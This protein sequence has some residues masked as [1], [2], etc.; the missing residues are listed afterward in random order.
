MD[1]SLSAPAD[2]TSSLFVPV[3]EDRYGDIKN[4]GL[5]QVA[6][7][8]SKQ[9]TSDLFAAEIILLQKGGPEKHLHYF[10]D[11]WFYALEGVLLF[12]V[13]DE[14]YR[15][16]P[17]DSVFAKKMVPHTWANISDTRMRLIALHTPAG[18]IEDFFINAARF[19]MPPGPNQEMWRPYDMEW[20]GPPIKID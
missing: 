5:S 2:K 9:E 1:N 11:E 17:G 19:K 10:Q 7:K 12:E 16:K 14:Q 20:V 4:L 18:K 6:L 8:I 13:G 3:G 15:M